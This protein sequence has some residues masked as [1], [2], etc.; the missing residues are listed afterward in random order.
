MA[1][2]V[3]CPTRAAFSRL[4]SMAIPFYIN[5]KYQSPED[6]ADAFDGAFTGIHIQAHLFQ[7]AREED[8]LE[9]IIGWYYEMG[10]TNLNSPFH[11]GLKTTLNVLGL[12]DFYQAAIN[13]ILSR[14]N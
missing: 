2:C 9:E 1:R 7:G 13:Y 11:D 6:R 12:Q 5:K 4:E 10:Q 3:S 14:S 8:W